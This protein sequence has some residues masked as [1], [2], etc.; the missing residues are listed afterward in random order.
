MQKV[1]IIWCVLYSTTI[2]GATNVAR[3]NDNS[4]LVN[5]Q[6]VSSIYG[7]TSHAKEMFLNNMT[8]IGGID[9][10]LSSVV[11]SQVVHLKI[12]TACGAGTTW[13]IDTSFSLTNLPT[14]GIPFHRSLVIRNGGLPVIYNSYYIFELSTDNNGTLLVTNTDSYNAGRYIYSTAAGNSGHTDSGQLVSFQNPDSSSGEKKQ[15]IMFV[16]WGTADSSTVSAPIPTTNMACPA[17]CQL[18][19]PA[20]VENAPNHSPMNALNVLIREE[21]FNNSPV[22]QPGS[23]WTDDMDYLKTHLVSNMLENSNPYASVKTTPPFGSTDG[24]GSTWYNTKMNFYVAKADP[25]NDPEYLRGFQYCA[26]IDII[27]D[28]ITGTG[29]TGSNGQQGSF[30]GSFGDPRLV[31]GVTA[32]LHEVLGHGFGGFVD[33]YVSPQETLAATDIPKSTLNSAFLGSGTTACADSTMSSWCTSSMSVSQLITAMASDP[34]K[35]CWTETSAQCDSDSA[36]CFNISGHN[37]PYFGSNV[38]IP[39]NVIFYNIGIGCNANSGCYIGGSVSLTALSLNV[40]QPSCSVMQSGHGTQ[41]PGFTGA[42]EPQF[43]TM[44]NCFFDASGCVGYNDATCTAFQNK[45]NSSS[46]PGNLG[47]LLDAN[48]CASGLSHRR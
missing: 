40:A 14:N 37:I 4:T 15:D 22:I 42:I 38:C 33:E 27:V 16:I 7:Q 12:G 18:V 48:A 23:F 34:Q 17:N 29:S 1:L 24:L 44:L 11:S 32:F 31:L 19:R 43:T 20:S 28:I 30:Q 46:G 3:T 21:R 10:Y 9:V 5:Q 47:F 25:A 2:A 36:N 39:R 8:L 6:L 35:G 41:Y 45:W 13:L 26:N